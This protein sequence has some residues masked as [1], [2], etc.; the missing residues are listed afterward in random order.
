[1]EDQTIIKLINS[2]VTVQKGFEIL[3]NTYQKKL[4]HH[5]RQMVYLHEDAE[6]VLQNVWLKVYKNIQNF[7]GDSQLSTW[8]YRIATNE[9]IDLIK[10]RSKQKKISQ[11]EYQEKAINNLKADQYFDGDQMTVK[12]HQAIVQLPEKQQ[13]VFRLR[14]FEEL[15]YKQ[16]A[17]ITGTSESALKSSY[18]FAVKK[19]EDLLSDD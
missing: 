6:D 1:M 15:S 9:S 12:L 13:L 14:Y 16:I 8:L 3:L 11:L 19:I 10:K 2:P 17:D 4:Y 18:H 5:V 7:R